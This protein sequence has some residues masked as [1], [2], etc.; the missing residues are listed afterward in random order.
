MVAKRARHGLPWSPEEDAELRRLCGEGAFVEDIAQAFS[1]S[2]ESVRT[3]ANVLA[4]PCRS[5]RRAATRGAK[6]KARPQ[7]A[8]YRLVCRSSDGDT[9]ETKELHVLT[10]A[11]AIGAAQACSAPG[12]CEIW[13]TGSDPELLGRH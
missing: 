3:R 11:D 13:K 4:I 8:G 12:G 2:A 6:S 10:D 5:A 9:I 7:P 1:R